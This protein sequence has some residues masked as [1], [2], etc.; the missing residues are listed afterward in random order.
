MATSLGT[1]VQVVKSQDQIRTLLRNND[2]DQMTFGD[3]FG[4]GI[5]FVY[6]RLIL[7]DDEFGDARLPVKVPVRLRP[8]IDILRREH[9]VK[10]EGHRGLSLATEQAMRVAWRNVYDWLRASFTA[11][12]VGIIT[13]AEA[14]LSGVVTEDGITVGQHILPRLPAMLHKG[15]TIPLIEAGT[16]Q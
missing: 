7:H 8:I 3:D 6:F 5:M 13:P 12:E 2:C 1:V 15:T 10:Y 9:P 14:F 16:P 11:V 4:E